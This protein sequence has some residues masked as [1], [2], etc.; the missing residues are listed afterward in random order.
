MNLTKFKP[1][2]FMHLASAKRI[3]V[4]SGF[5]KGIVST[6]YEEKPNS[7]EIFTSKG[8]VIVSKQRCRIIED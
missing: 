1:N 4:L 3:E 2:L 7:Y 6:E 8:S 5:H